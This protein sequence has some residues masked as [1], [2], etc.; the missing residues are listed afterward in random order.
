MHKTVI[1]FIVLE[2]PTRGAFGSRV[3]RNAKKAMH[4]HSLEMGGG[5]AAG[6]RIIINA[7]ISRISKPCPIAPLHSKPMILL[8]DSL[9]LL[10]QIY[11]ARPTR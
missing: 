10:V 8:S 9:A 6:S 7:I 4:F 2:L 1:L 3:I 5:R 11:K